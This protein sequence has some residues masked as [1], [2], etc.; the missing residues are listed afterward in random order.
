[1]GVKREQALVRTDPIGAV[2]I[3]VDEAGAIWH[4]GMGYHFSVSVKQ[5][6]PL[7]PDREP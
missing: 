5:V 6:K 1:M 2:V 4:G 3:A 7:I